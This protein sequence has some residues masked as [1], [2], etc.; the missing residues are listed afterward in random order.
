M[1]QVWA[2]DRVNKKLDLLLLHVTHVRKQ[3]TDVA[4][5]GASLMS[6][7]VSILHDGLC[8]FVARNFPTHS[9]LRLTSSPHK[10]VNIVILYDSTK[11]NH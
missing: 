10:V 8:S 2:R 1:A 4:H 11:C 9:P 6:D 5:E 3:Q 7:L